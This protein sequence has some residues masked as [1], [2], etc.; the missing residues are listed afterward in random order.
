M[1]ESTAVLFC[2]PV[3]DFT[4]ALKYIKFTKS[5]ENIT[6]FENIK[7]FLAWFKTFCI[8]SSVAEK[9]R[10]VVD[11]FNFMNILSVKLT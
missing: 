9:K 3:Y 1:P 11:S 2:D 7:K 10:S 5:G 6:H 8:I 4:H